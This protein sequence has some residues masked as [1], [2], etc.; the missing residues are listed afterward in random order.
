MRRQLSLKSASA[1]R[2]PKAW[3]AANDNPDRKANSVDDIGNSGDDAEEAQQVPADNPD[4]RIRCHVEAETRFVAAF[5]PNVAEETVDDSRHSAKR[6]STPEVLSHVRRHRN[7]QHE[8]R[9]APG[10]AHN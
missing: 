2:S 10:T 9:K 7:Q 4:D 1:N 3:P 6:R 8:D 5:H